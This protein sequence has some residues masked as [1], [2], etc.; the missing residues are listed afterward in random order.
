MRLTLEA[1]YSIPSCSVTACWI[2]CGMMLKIQVKV[3]IIGVNRTG[4][5]IGSK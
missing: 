3:I 1:F 5:S 2:V 4:D